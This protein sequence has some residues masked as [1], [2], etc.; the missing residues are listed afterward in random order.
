MADIHIDIGACK[1]SKLNAVGHQQVNYRHG[2]RHLAD[3]IKE[4]I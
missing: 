2:T 3:Q 1:H 4:L